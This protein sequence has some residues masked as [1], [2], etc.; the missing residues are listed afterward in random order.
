MSS[1]RL[2]RT[3]C[4]THCIS[5]KC[6]QRHSAWGPPTPSRRID[7]RIANC[8]RMSWE[9]LRSWRNCPAHRKTSCSCNATCRCQTNRQGTSGTHHNT[10]PRS[11]TRTDPHPQLCKILEHGTW[12][13]ALEP[14]LEQVPAAG[15]RSRRRHSHRYKKGRFRRCTCTPKANAE[16]RGLQEL[17]TVTS[18]SGRNVRQTSSGPPGCCCPNMHEHLPS[19]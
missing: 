6:F 18:P 12:T 13:M 19:R 5:C 3:G 10:G 2:G 1:L 17:L 4:S 8:Q 7:H 16:F 15:H 14:A 11:Q 9:C